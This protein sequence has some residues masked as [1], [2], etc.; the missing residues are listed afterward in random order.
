MSSFIG[1]SLAA[2]TIHKSIGFS[3][4]KTPTKLDR[5]LWLGWLILVAVAPDLDAFIP[6]LHSSAHEGLRITHSLLSCQI[7][8][9][10]TTLFLWIWGLRKRDLLIAGL[11]VSSIGFSQII[12]DLLVG[13]TPLPLLWPLSSQIFKLSFG[14]LPS[15]GKL[16]LSNYYLY[17]NLLI[18]LGVLAP[19]SYC[20]C[21]LSVAKQLTWGDRLTILFLILIS[22][23]FMYFAYGLSR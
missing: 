15:A 10:L 5:L 18:E 3:P 21:R 8:P 6:A 20:T 13:V 23:R 12:L 2:W 9:I 22:A 11:Q 17:Y 1:H 7:L 4:H 14:V 19:L 16:H